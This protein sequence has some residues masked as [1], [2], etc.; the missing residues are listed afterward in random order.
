MEKEPSIKFYGVLIISQ[1][2]IKSRSLEGLD[3][4]DV[5]ATNVHNM[6]FSAV[7]SVL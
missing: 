7:H 3:V 6:R 1:E 2:V 5:I 4:S